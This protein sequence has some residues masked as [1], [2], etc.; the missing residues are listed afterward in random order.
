MKNTFLLRSLAVLSAAIGV[1]LLVA[2][3]FPLISYQ[4]SSER[5]TK[6][7]SPVPEKQVDYTNASTWF[8]TNNSLSSVESGVRYYTITVPKLG[9]KDVTV[10]MG[11]EDLSEYLIQYPGTAQPGKRGNTVV[12]GHSVL[13]QFFN[14]N[15]YLTVFSTLPTLKKGDYVQVEYDGVSY[16]YKIYDMFEVLPTDLNV[17]SQDTAGSTLSL[18]TCVP[19]GDPRRPKRL[20]VKAGL[21][22]PSEVTLSAR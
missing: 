19:P 12:F 7:I 10:S 21:V 1:S 2:V 18:V 6:L 4:F 9:I 22:P 5:F 14:P 3:C 15:D 13:P 17:L 8:P 20:I 16:T 11:G